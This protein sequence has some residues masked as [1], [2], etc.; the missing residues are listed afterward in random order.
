MTI[1]ASSASA[2][3]AADDYDFLFDESALGEQLGAQGGEAA[4][5]G[6]PVPAQAQ[7]PAIGNQPA[8]AAAPDNGTLA[9]MQAQLQALQAQ[10]TLLMHQQA[11]Y[12]QPQQLQQPQPARAFEA[13]VINMRDIEAAL[14]PEQRELFRD[15]G[16]LLDTMMKVQAQRYGEALTPL[17]TELDSLR[18]GTSQLA[19]G[20]E[21]RLTEQ[22][23]HAFNA[24]M[25]ATLPGMAATVATPG[26]RQY[27]AEIVPMSGG[28]S[29]SAVLM[30][31]HSRRDLGQISE[32]FNAFQQ[33]GA[34]LAK[35]PGVQPAAGSASAAPA[36]AVAAAMQQAQVPGINE[37][38]EAKIDELTD[39]Y[40]RGLITHAA[41]T[42]AMDQL[43]E[44]AVRG[45]V[46]K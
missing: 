16:P 41:Y 11:M 25:A 46:L 7:Q 31:A 37:V 45:A 10:N 3:Q 23:T 14:T 8:P 29:V 20:V 4:M 18:T 9:Q 42:R 24:T 35:P 39:R 34:A 6:Q 30:D 17:L 32:I 19:Q 28:R 26:W 12:A 15:F 2:N 40:Q 44:L 27:L 21:Q 36:G 43:T 33:R 38:S 22:S 5:P 13:P 1:A